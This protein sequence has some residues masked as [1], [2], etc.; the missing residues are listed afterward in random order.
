MKKLLSMFSLSL[1][2]V[3]SACGS[4]GEK[5]V[6][7]GK[8][9]KET[10]YESI[11][12]NEEHP[13]FLDDLESAMSFAKEHS[14]KH[15]ALENVGGKNFSEYM[16]ETI[17]LYK[18]FDSQ[19]IITDIQIYLDKADEEIGVKEALSLAND[20]LSSDFIQE[21]YIVEESF[22][23]VPKDKAKKENIVIKYRMNDES[24]EDEA[25]N[26]PLSF[27]VILELKDDKVNLIWLNKDKPKWMNFLEKNG[28]M[29]EDWDMNQY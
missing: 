17:I 1:V 5:T 3:L 20:Y 16:D 27:N 29:K 25:L 21:N 6:E 10:P 2:L 24:K 13:L 28:Y 12:L 9:T 8:E 22:K 19:G 23:I 7:I 11:V 4:E 15:I 18:G 14:K 26:Q